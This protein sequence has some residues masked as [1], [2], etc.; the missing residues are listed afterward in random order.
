M[1]ERQY[2][3]RRRKWLRRYREIHKKH[4]GFDLSD[5]LK[6]EV[7][8]ASAEKLEGMTKALEN[9]AFFGKSSKVR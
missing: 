9:A 2:Q 4:Y 3:K 7:E 5:E 8:A 1:N 6:K